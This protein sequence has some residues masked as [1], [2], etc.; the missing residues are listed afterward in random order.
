MMTI[1]LGV[2]GLDITDATVGAFLSLCASKGQRIL[3]GFEA[4]GIALSPFYCILFCQSTTNQYQ[5]KGKGGGG[6]NLV[7]GELRILLLKDA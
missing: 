5:E 3:A 6:S 4:I 1:G 2:E 7:V